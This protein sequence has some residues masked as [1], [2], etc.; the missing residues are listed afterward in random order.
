V[1]LPRAERQ[2]RATNAISADHAPVLW[3]RIGAQL[4]TLA[5]LV[6]NFQPQRLV[7][8]DDSGRRARL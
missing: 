8:G 5:L 7:F 2:G 1:I 3:L 6:V 4:V